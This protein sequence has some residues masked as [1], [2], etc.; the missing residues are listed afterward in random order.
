M[1]PTTPHHPFHIPQQS[2]Q[3]NWRFQGGFTFLELI[4]YIALIAIFISGSIVFAW[5]LILGQVKSR[6][7]QEVTQNGRLAAQRLAYE[8]RNASSINSVSATSVCLA[9][10]TDARNPTRFYLSGG[11]LRVAWGG[12]SVNCTSMTNDQPL[13]SNQ[14][15]VSGL[16]F[17]DR[18]NGASENIE[19]TFTVSATG[20]RQEWQDSQ[21]YADTIE[22]RSN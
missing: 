1:K 14:V 20:T 13:T 21:T 5:D 10:A 9:S 12:G 19:F 11:Q 18:S 22:L 6:V 2:C 4:L 7:Q 3:R 15:T 16:N 17:T 8:I